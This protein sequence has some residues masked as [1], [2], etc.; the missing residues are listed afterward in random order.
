MGQPSFQASN[1]IIYVTYGAFLFDLMTKIDM[2]LSLIRFTQDLRS[3][4]CLALQASVQIGISGEQPDAEGS[5]TKCPSMKEDL[6]SAAIW[7]CHDVPNSSCQPTDMLLAFPLAL[8]FIASGE[9]VSA[10]RL[11]LAAAAMNRT[12]RLHDGMN[13]ILIMDISRP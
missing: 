5:A 9:C 3:I 1:A 8:N 6:S 2:S 7:L 13:A 11:L 4:Y 10:L 12:R